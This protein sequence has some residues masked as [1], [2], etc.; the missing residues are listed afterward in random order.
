MD[1][2]TFIHRMRQLRVIDRNALLIYADLARTVPHREL[3]D[4]FRALARDEAK[5]V[6][7][8]SELF[9]IFGVQPG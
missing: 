5:H 4:L 3:A 1:S 9:S 7:L 6:R 8:E 2:K